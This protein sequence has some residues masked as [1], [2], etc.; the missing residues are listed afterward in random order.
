MTSIKVD[1]SEAVAKLDPKTME[2]HLSVALDGAADLIRADIKKYPAPPAGSSYQRTGTLGRSWAKKVN[3]SAL[4]AVIGSNVAY[5]PYV[6]DQDRQA[7]MHKGR[8]QTAQGVAR[9]QARN[10]QRFIERA[11]ARW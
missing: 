9:D 3:R 11:L 4:R 1:V 2:K 8:W 5:A 10:V 7:W 6:Q